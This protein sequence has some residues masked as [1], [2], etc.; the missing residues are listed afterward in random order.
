MG[1]SVFLL[2]VRLVYFRCL[3]LS[4]CVIVWGPLLGFQGTLLKT[5]LSAIRL[6]WGSFCFMV[7]K[8]S[9]ILEGE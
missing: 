3:S 8:H 5:V 9:L 7:C 1:L 4:F 6:S 2:D